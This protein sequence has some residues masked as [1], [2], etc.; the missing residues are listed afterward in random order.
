MDEEYEL[1][2]GVVLKLINLYNEGKIKPKI[3][4]VWSFDQ[5][6]DAMK[7]MQEK[8]NVGKVI[9]VPEAPKEESKKA[10]N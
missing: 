4:S 6:A 8:K 10:E 3:D 2:T 7:H 5:V 9:L 1:I